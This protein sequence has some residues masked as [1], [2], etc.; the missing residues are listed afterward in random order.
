MSDSG[1]SGTP[2][3]KKLGYK[4]GFKCHLEHAPAE[5]AQWIGDL[6]EGCHYPARKKD[7]DLVHYFTESESALIR[8]MP[9]LR[10]MILSSGMIWI[11][12]PKKSSGVVTDM[13]EDVV[14]GIGLSNDLVDIKVCAVS[15]IW[16]ALKFVIP[17]KLR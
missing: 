6:P 4:P 8:R 10:K 3:V 2:L 17:K 13:T 12:W 14:R 11:S 7:L 9:E 1:Y 15:S 16:S 5:Y